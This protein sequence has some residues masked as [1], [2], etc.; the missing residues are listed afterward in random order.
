M[1]KYL[2]LDS[3]LFWTT[4]YLSFDVSK[5]TDKQDKKGNKYRGISDAVTLSIIYDIYLSMNFH[6]RKQPYSPLDYY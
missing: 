2:R 4:V 1:A 3:W 6:F 5:S